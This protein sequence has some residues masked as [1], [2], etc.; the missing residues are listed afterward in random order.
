MSNY[1]KSTVLAAFLAKDEASEI[2][3]DDISDKGYTCFDQNLLN[4]GSRE[5]I[6]CTNEEADE[7]AREAISDSLWAFNLDFLASITRI[8]RGVFKALQELCERSNPAVLSLVKDTC[9]L[10][11][12]VEEAVFTD[13][14]GNF[15]SSYDGK[16]HYYSYNG[17]EFYIYRIN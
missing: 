2:T 9:G 8:D 11:K 7:A 16:E 14:R 6:V 12:F 4:Y 1:N 13:G 3:E 15:L 17:E 10:D 5:Y